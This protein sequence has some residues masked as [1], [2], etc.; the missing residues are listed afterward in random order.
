MLY[1]ETLLCLDDLIEERFVPMVGFFVYKY[2]V[3]L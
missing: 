2:Y 1:N 3:T